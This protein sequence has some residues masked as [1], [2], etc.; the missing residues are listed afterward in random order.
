[1][2]AAAPA[3]APAP[4]GSARYQ[5]LR[6]I[7]QALGRFI[8]AEA[9]E[10]LLLIDQQALSLALVRAQL[11]PAAPSP[12]RALLSPRVVELDPA[13]LQRF[14]GLAPALAQLGVVAEDFG[15]SALILK[16]LPLALSAADPDA[17]LPALL[18]GPPLAGEPG[19]PGLGAALVERL[20]ALAVPAEQQR[21]LYE[22]RELLKRVDAVLAVPPFEDL[23]R[24]RLLSAGELDRL[25]RGGRP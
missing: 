6:L 4:S 12:G 2:A 22:L 17:L 24:C 7:G 10:G 20:S 23:A 25:L 11:E 1:V 21:S 14:A 13:A 18:R 5:D 15:P 3:P 16:Q 8:L 19:G 9:P